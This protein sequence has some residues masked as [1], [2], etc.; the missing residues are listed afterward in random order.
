MRRDA[1]TQLLCSRYRVLFAEYRLDATRSGMAWGFQ[2]DDG[3]FTIVDALASVLTAHA[4]EATAAYVKQ[5][6]GAMGFSLHE[7]DAFTYGACAAA[8]RFSMTISEV[9][10]R[11]GVLMVGRQGR[12]LKTLAPGELAGFVPV[13]RDAF[14]ADGAG[15]CSLEVVDFH[16]GPRSST[17]GPQACGAQGFH[18]AIM[19]RLHP[20]TGACGPVN[21]QGIMASGTEDE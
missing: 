16:A 17:S 14:Q 7:G 9:S 1:L 3:W 10:G 12:W 8:K 11:R 2:H 4:P 15:H 6:M 21:D 20:V 5:K 19:K 13:S 18:Q